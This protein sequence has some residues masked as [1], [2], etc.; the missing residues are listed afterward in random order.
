M[1]PPAK[2]LGFRPFKKGGLV[3]FAKIQ[4]GSGMI[5]NDIPVH[6]ARTCAREITKLPT[7]SEVASFST[8]RRAQFLERPGADR[9]ARGASGTVPR[10]GD[11]PL[12]S[13]IMSREKSPA[14]VWAGQA[15]GIDTGGEA[16]ISDVL[17]VH[18]RGDD[19]PPDR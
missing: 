4:S 11:C 12:R 6:I 14:V 15:E 8:P 16:R 2:L 7:Y 19:L 10:A 5:F 18:L 1:R 17:T 13:M 3:G 9:S